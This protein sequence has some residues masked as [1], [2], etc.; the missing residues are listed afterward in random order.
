MAHV[1]TTVLLGAVAL[2]RNG[3]LLI[4]LVLPPLAAGTLIGWRIY[5]HLNDRAF[6][7]L[8]SA[9]L[10]ISGVALVV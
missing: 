10:L 1:A 7:R 4:L 3:V 5:G 6:R 8:L 9:M 2:D